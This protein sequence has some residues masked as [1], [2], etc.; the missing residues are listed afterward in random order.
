[1]RRSLAVSLRIRPIDMARMHSASRIPAA[2]AQPVIAVTDG[3]LDR[4]SMVSPAA[5]AATRALLICA[6]VGGC[7]VCTSQP[8]TN[9]VRPRACTAC[10]VITVFG[11]DVPD[12]SAPTV[13]ITGPARQLVRGHGQLFGPGPFGPLCSKYQP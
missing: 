12:G 11:A 7:A 6:A 1:M 5:A 9:G 13:C 3:M 8:D 2:V 4:V 10:S